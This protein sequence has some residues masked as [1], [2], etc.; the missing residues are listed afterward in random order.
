VEESIERDTC[1]CKKCLGW[2]ESIP[3]SILIF[4]KHYDNDRK[5]QQAPLSDT[6]KSTDPKPIRTDNASIGRTD[7]PIRQ[8]GDSKEQTKAKEVHFRKVAEEHVGKKLICAKCGEDL[9]GKG[10]V[11]RGGKVYCAVVGCG[12]PARGDAKA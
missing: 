9:T 6:D 12:Y 3:S 10:T 5:Q 2:N 1:F 4:P 7:I 8:A 11:E